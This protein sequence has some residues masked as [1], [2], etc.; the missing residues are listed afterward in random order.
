MCSFNQ[1]ERSLNWPQDLDGTTR[2]VELY[3]VNSYAQVRCF[4]V[5]GDDLMIILA[6]AIQVIT[7]KLTGRVTPSLR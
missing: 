7:L 1:V 6:V 2:L 3:I 4:A 5:T